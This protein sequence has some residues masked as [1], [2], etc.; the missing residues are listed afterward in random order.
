VVAARDRF[1]A[2]SASLRF[3]AHILARCD[4]D[5]DEILESARRAAGARQLRDAIAEIARQ[6]RLQATLLETL[7]WMRRDAPRFLPSGGT[8]ADL[9]VSRPAMNLARDARYLRRKASIIERRATAAAAL[10]AKPLQG[11]VQALSVVFRNAINGMSVDRHCN[12]F[13]EAQQV[14]DTYRPFNNTSVRIVWNRADGPVDL[15]PGQVGA[16]GPP[17]SCICADAVGES[18]P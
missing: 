8:V 3:G 1:V 11:P 4:L 16:R 12:T 2:L 18:A 17:P 14:A 5:V 9:A 10:A 15:D 6:M 13:A 7:V